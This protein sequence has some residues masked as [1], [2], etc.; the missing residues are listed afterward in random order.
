MPAWAKRV[1][2]EYYLVHRG[3]WPLPQYQLP[4]DRDY[5]FAFSIEPPGP[6]KTNKLPTTAD[7]VPEAKTTVRG[8]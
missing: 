7:R 6:P 2:L 5:H 3:D 1:R 4:A 8:Q